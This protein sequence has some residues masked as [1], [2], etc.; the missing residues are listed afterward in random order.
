MEIR[1]SILQSN[2]K[3]MISLIIYGL[4]MPFSSLQVLVI[5]LYVYSYLSFFNYE[6][7]H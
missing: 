5:V 2:S 7:L 4:L 3:L 6:S 1:K